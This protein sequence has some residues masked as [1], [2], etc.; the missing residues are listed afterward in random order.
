MSDFFKRFFKNENHSNGNTINNFEVSTDSG[1]TVTINGK[2]YSGNHIQMNGN[3]VVVDGER[4]ND[5]EEKE[6][7]ITV[8]GDVKLKIPA[9]TQPGKIIR[10]RGRGVPHLRSNSRGDQLVIVN[11][12]IPKR[13]DEEERELFE[14]LAQKMDSKVLP[15]EKGFLDRLKNVLGG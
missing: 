15:Q 7:T 10:M 3:K 2:T 11:V 14:K 12:T 5:I 8:D 13:L 6:I 9:G 4:V 1:T